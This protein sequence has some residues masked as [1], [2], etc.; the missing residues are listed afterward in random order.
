LTPVCGALPAAGRI[1]ARHRLIDR[2]RGS[3]ILADRGE[4]WGRL[5]PVT[6]RRL[7]R[8]LLV[9]AASQGRDG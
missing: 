8:L 6:S 9:A 3:L 2:R 5:G 7:G 1:L 4:R